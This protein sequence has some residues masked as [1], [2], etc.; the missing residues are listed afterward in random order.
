MF[1]EEAKD[2]RQAY[3][4]NLI[5]LGNDIKKKSGADLTIKDFLLKEEHLTEIDTE[6]K[7]KHQRAMLE[8][9]QIMAENPN[10]KVNK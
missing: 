10:S 3:T 5:A 2:L 9:M 1:G 8:V 4:S 6:L 7:Q